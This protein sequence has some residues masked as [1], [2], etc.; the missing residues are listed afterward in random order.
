MNAGILNTVGLTRWPVGARFGE[1]STPAPSNPYP[2]YLQVTGTAIPNTI[3]GVY[4]KVEA[5]PVAY[6]THSDESINSVISWDDATSNWIITY[7]DG[8]TEY[9]WINA[10]SSLEEGPRGTFVAGSGVAEGTAIVS[11][12]SGT[13]EESLFGGTGLFGTFATR[14]SSVRRGKFSQNPKSK[15]KNN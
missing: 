5:S 9:V 4:N 1:T 2:T 12:Y 11:L 10:S 13:G 6:W 7:T 15:F 8:E 3:L 14:F